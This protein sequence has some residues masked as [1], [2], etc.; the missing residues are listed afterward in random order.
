MK[1]YSKSDLINIL[2]F[3]SLALLF[4]STTISDFP[5]FENIISISIF[6]FLIS[7]LFLFVLIEG[8]KT[9]RNEGINILIGLLVIIGAPLLIGWFIFQ[10]FY[11]TFYFT[12]GL[13]F[14]L[15]SISNYR[16]N[17][18]IIPPANSKKPRKSRIVNL[19]TTTKKNNEA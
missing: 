3:F 13:G 1:M 19:D 16:S 4:L 15:I 6:A 17:G 8:F 18:T 2:V 14:L 11:D 5:L 10:D 9:S 7:M 12:L